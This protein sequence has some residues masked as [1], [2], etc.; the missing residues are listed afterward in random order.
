MEELSL[1]ALDVENPGLQV[2]QPSLVPS[3]TS[4]YDE[5]KHCEM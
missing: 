3:P 5:E 2:S 1:L 4:S